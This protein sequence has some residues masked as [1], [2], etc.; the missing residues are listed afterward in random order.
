[1]VLLGCSA[2]TFGTPRDGVAPARLRRALNIALSWPSPS[3][4]EALK[5]AMLFRDGAPVAQPDLAI[6]RAILRTNPRMMQ[7]F[8]L[9]LAVDTV[10]AAR[11]ND[12]PPEFLASTLLQESAYNVEALSSAGAVGI[13]Q[14]MPSTAAEAGV[15]PYDPFDAIQGAAALLASYVEE[16]RGRYDDPYSTALA[17]YNAGPEAV[18]WYDGIPPYAETRQYVALIFDRWAAIASYERPAPP[19]SMLRHDTALR[20]PKPSR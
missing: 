16:Y 14:F 10:R 1:M 8:A 19:S 15:N 11:R 13:A 12:L 6:A 9:L 18:A 4:V 20:K 17:A 2:H 7:S 5:G 3:R